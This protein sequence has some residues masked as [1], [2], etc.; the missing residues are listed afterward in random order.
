MAQPVQVRSDVDVDIRGKRLAVLR[1]FYARMLDDLQRAQ[2][3]G[4]VEAIHDA[5]VG[6]RRLRVVLK[7]LKADCQPIFVR[8]LLFDLRD[9]GRALAP[10]RDA[11][12]KRQMLATL[13]RRMSADNPNEVHELRMQLQLHCAR[14]RHELKHRMRSDNWSSRLQR[15]ATC[16]AEDGLL[17]LPHPTRRLNPERA[18]LEKRLRSIRKRL[19]N[20]HGTDGQRLHSLRIKVKQARYLCEFLSEMN[21]QVPETVLHRSKK[22]QTVLGK[23]HDEVQLQRWL[24]I[25]DMSPA[26]RSLLQEHLQMSLDKH[27]RQLGELRRSSAELNL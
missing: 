11:D 25:A 12:V 10:V 22:L 24:T 1:V 21:I 19:K 7:A 20:K 14:M 4:G 26:L 6:A 18:A 16:F 2:R 5:R 3:T 13:L 8:S 17:A 27:R 23:L 9:I 15:M